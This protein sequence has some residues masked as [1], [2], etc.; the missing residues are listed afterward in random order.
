MEGSKNSSMSS[1]EFGKP[2]PATCMNMSAHNYDKLEADGFVAP[3]TR[4]SGSDIII[5]KTSPLP[6]TVESAMSKRAQR[7]TRR[8]SSTGLRHSETGIV[9]QVMLTTN[10]DDGAKFVKVRVRSVRT[11]QIG[12]KFASRHGQK[13]T[14]GITY[15]Q[16][17]M[18]WTVEG[19]SP[20]II[21][22]PHAIP[23]RM[24]VGHLIECLLGKV[25]SLVGDAGIATPFDPGVTVERISGLLHEAGYQRRGNEV[26]YNGH[27]GQRLD[28][29]I[30]L[31]PTFY[32]RLKHMVDD[33]IHSRARGPLQILTRQPV[34]GRSRDGGLRFGEMERD[35]MISHGAAHMMRDRL[36]LNSDQ[37]RVHICDFCGLIAI[38]NLKKNAFE[39]RG[40]KNTTQIS[41]V[42]MP[43]ACKLL[44]QE[45][46]AMAIAPRM[47]TV[48]T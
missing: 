20:D 5:G 43:Y 32:Q 17:D 13:G 47:V 30:F 19:I 40:C 22:N 29:M 3:G 12:D 16:E 45:L 14:C 34:E 10:P 11:P 23:S 26:M 15:R 42:Y 41:Q 39:C 27:T 25:A 37:Y 9:D 35:C 6:V 38:A 2:T 1:E 44:F 24:T 28:A 7:Q 36:F 4:V 31:G 46:M 33:K 48:P 21:V 8:D 18:P